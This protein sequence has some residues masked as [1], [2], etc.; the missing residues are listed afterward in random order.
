MNF[1]D[2]R[3]W[4]ILREIILYYVDVTV[5]KRCT[6]TLYNSPRISY[7]RPSNS[8]CLP[9]IFA[10]VYNLLKNMYHLSEETVTN[11]YF[12]ST[13]SLTTDATDILNPSKRKKKHKEVPWGNGTVRHSVSPYLCTK[14]IKPAAQQLQ[15]TLVHTLNK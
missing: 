7:G 8:T 15:K 1:S 3:Y 2:F 4:F 5:L 10:F 12:Y 11:V 14:E 13:H 9:F 6:S